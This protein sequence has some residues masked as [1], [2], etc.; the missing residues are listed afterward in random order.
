[1]TPTA[2]GKKESALKNEDKENQEE[3]VSDWDEDSD[4]GVT[5]SMSGTM[6]RSRRA[7]STHVNVRDRTSGLSNVFANKDLSKYQGYSFAS[8]LDTNSNWGQNSSR[9]FS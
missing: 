4:G 5:E 1:M 7:S 2:H 8:G 6:R 3:Q 9:A